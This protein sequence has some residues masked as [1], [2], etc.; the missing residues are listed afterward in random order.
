MIATQV[1]ESATAKRDTPYVGLR[2]FTEEDAAIFFGREAERATLIRNLRAARLTLLYAQ[3]GTGKSSLL[4]AG[5]ASRLKELAQRGLAERGTAR[6]IPVVFSSWRD[7]PTD[8]L[9]TEIRNRT[10]DFPCPQ[11]PAES[12]PHEESAPHEESP[13]RKLRP[14]EEAL[15]QASKATNAT[16]LVILDQFEE[17]FL[18]RSEE[19]PNGR[20]AD[21]LAA[22]VNRGDLRANFLISIREDAYSGLGDLFQSRIGNVYANY[23]HLENLTAASAREAIEKP[24]ASYNQEHQDEQPVEIEPALVGTVLGQ[25]KPD[26]FMLD[27][28]GKGRLDD[29]NG[30]R[31]HQDEIAAPYLQLVMERLWEAEVGTGSRKLRLHTLEQLGGAQ[32]VVRTHVDR[33]LSSLPSTDREAAVD[34]LY[35]LVTPSGT[36]IALTAADLAEYTNRPV[37][38]VTALLER[39]ASTE[40]RI[41]RTVPAPHGKDSG[42]RY[43]ITHDLLAPAILEWGGRQKAARL[44]QEKEAAEQRTLVEKRR[45]RNFR[46]LA[47]GS[48][49]VLVVA[50]VLAVLAFLNGSAAQTA[51]HQAESRGLAASAEALL[52]QNPEQAAKRA[53]HALNVAHTPEAQAALR[54]ALPQLQLQATLAAP[55]A[56]RSATFST[57][58][59]QI[60]TAAADGTIRIW[61]AASHQQLAQ[62]RITGGSLNSAALNRDGTQ[63]VA[64]SDDGAA[65][66]IDVPGGQVTRVLQAPD[67]RALSSAAFSPNGRLIVTAGADGMARLWNAHTGAP[68][69]SPINV[70]QELFDAAFSPDGTRI[71]TIGSAGGARIWSVRTGQLLAILGSGWQYGAS[72]SPD[73]KRLVTVSGGN[74]TL[75]VWNVVTSQEIGRPIASVSGYE[76]LSTAFSPDGK[77][78]LAAST[79]GSARIWNAAS[80]RLVRVLR[81]AGRGSLETAAFSPDG[82]SIVTAGSDGVVRGWDAGTGRQVFLLRAGGSNQLRGAAFSPDGRLAATGS[83]YGIVAIWRKTVPKSGSATWTLVRSISL[84]EGDAVNGVA[85]SRN[86]KLLAAASQSGNVF[87]VEVPS[88]AYWGALNAIGRAVN[89][90]EFDPADPLLVLAASDDGLARIY[91]WHTR[92]QVGR[93]FGSP[94]WPIHGAAF[95]P[96]GKL[97]VTASND[98][99][100]RLWNAASQHQV[101]KKFGYGNSMD[102]AVFDGNKK[103]I[104]TE[105]D[106][107][108]I[109]WDVGRGT[110]RYNSEIIEPG[111]NIPNDAA[112]SPDGKLVVTGGTDG[113]A[114]EWDAS[115]DNLVLTFAGHTGPIQTVAFSGSEVLTASLDGTAKLWDDAPFEQREL[116]PGPDASLITASFSPTNGHLVATASSNGTLRVWNTQRKTSVTGL[117]EPSSTGI[118]SAEFSHSGK[119]IVTAGGEQAKVYS[120][121]NLHRPIGV[122]N[123]AKY[124]MCSN[125]PNST[126]A[127]SMYSATFSPNDKQ[128]VTSDADGIACI[129][130]VGT[131]SH[132]GTF[133]P[134]RAL[135]EPAGTSAGV[136]GIGAVGRSG[137]RW[138]VFSPAGNRILTASDDGTARIWDASNGRLLHT[139][140]EPTG[141]VLNSAWFSP[142]GRL[143]VTASNDGTA[144]IWSAATGGLLHVLSEPGRSAV[145]NAA[146]SH[147]GRFIVTCSGTDAR[148]WNT[149]TG[150]Q[151]TEFQYGT[152]SDCEFSPDGSEVVTAGDD[153]Q[154]RIFSTELATGLAQLQRIA[155][156]WIRR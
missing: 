57:G 4:R 120:V 149:K 123:T 126:T 60:L 134:V 98:G 14:L 69:G 51:R 115:S 101:G 116:L 110:P 66:I 89:R 108:T 86:G 107:Y 104:T 119:L 32:T 156:Q 140:S 17:Y 77:Q 31:P 111:T 70:G 143:V 1:A 59:N 154:A 52:S 39:L 71:V 80:G 28:G 129:W 81:T 50:S 37:D 62:V 34:I 105:N 36:K 99:Y 85:F 40:T 97:I 93:S 2:I 148:I 109:I 58:G 45:V 75:R 20:F 63:I 130:D 112:A 65:R 43:E 79:G 125:N 135:T 144:R 139:M 76:F 94:N 44:E 38:R 84:P 8:E 56:V 145:Y 132:P 95:S 127:G 73:G 35:H 141:E 54:N 90:V 61:D 128:V 12:P 21:E 10:S 106:G 48:L 152:I 124:S 150:Q 9:I 29:A 67:G 87:F 121:S 138:A 42:I 55:A 18:Y 15:E 133:T 83:R 122:L 27:Q 3:S 88:G 24:L 23:L 74:S 22:C 113:T 25:L 155:G 7:E 92:K 117:A 6:N 147:N 11:P 142:D 96:D 53:L 47:V 82:K 46:A 49:A 136:V 151:L 137:L 5:V 131:L 41:L 16:L 33:A 68:L 146:F 114:R 100:A 72:F 91:N 118:A 64:A 30:G 102:S 153:G 26:Q 19:K 13:P 78:V 103:I